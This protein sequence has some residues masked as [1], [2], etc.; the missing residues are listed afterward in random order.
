MNRIDEIFSQK[1]EEG[2]PVL[3]YREMLS[4]DMELLTLTERMKDNGG[5]WELTAEQTAAKALGQV[6]KLRELGAEK[7]PIVL[8]LPFQK[9]F[10]HGLKDFVQGCIE[11]GVDGIRVENLPS[12]EQPQLKVYLLS[13]GAPYLIQEVCPQSGDRIP[14]VTQMCRGFV[15]CKAEPSLWDQQEEYGSP[16][17]F[18]LYATWAVSPVPL[19]LDFQGTPLEALKPYLETAQGAVVY[20][21]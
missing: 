13:D 16:L 11:A 9:V 1:K 17:L 5:I 7:L 4:G 19:V 20:Q 6:K 21:P 8:R 14:L 18:F 10:H 12:E 2:A 15:Y 3:V